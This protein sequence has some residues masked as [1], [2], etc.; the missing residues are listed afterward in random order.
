VVSDVWTNLQRIIES[1]SPM[2][3][4]DHLRCS[5]LTRAGRIALRPWTNARAPTVHGYLTWVCVKQLS[6]RALSEGQAVQG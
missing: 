1:S 5:V 2:G 4:T 3:D 6:D